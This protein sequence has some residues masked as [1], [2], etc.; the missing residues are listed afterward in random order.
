MAHAFEQ[1]GEFLRFD[2]VRLFAGH[3]LIIGDE[4]RVGGGLLKAFAQS[5]DRFLRRALGQDEAALQFRADV[6]HQHQRVIFRS[7]SAIL[8]ESVL[9]RLR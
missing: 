5:F 7:G 3:F 2:K 4:I 8:A 9:Y 6:G 1:R